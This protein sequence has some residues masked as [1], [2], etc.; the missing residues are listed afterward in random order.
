MQN[1]RIGKGGF[2]MTRRMSGRCRRQANMCA[3]YIGN[4]LSSVLP[5]YW[6][7]II[8]N[9]LISSHWNISTFF[10]RSLWTWIETT[11]RFRFQRTLLIL[12]DNHSGLVAFFRFHLC[13]IYWAWAGTGCWGKSQQEDASDGKALQLV[14][15]GGDNAYRLIENTLTGLSI[16]VN[17]F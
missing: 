13:W 7:I 1:L 11:T 17:E 9:L 8:N 6:P 12:I 16:T 14:L 15:P 3:A 10:L 2:G 5:S 4:S